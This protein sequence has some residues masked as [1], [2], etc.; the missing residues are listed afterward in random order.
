M[1][2][3]DADR[4]NFL[5]LPTDDDTLIRYWSLDEDDR[6]LL[7]TRRRNDTRLGLALQ[8]CALR[9]PGRLIQRGEVIPE[10]ALTFLAEQLGVDPD[11]IST[12][13]RR[14]PTR[15]EQLAILRQHYGFSELTHPLRADLL[16]FSCGVALAS[17]KDK[18]VVAALAD[19][20]RRRR[21]IIPGITV[22]ERL[23]GQACTE[24]EEALFADVARRLA[25]DLVVRMEA[26]LGMGP[27]A[28]QSGISWLREPPGKA[29]ASSMRGLID[30]LMAVRHVGISGHVLQAVPTHRVR[31]MAQEGRRLT[32]QNFEQ[33]RPGRRHATLAAFLL[34]TEIA[35]TDATIAMFET[36]IGKSF[37]QAE[38]LRDQKLLETATTA[39]S[40]L[41][42]FASFGDAI[43]ARRETGLSLDEAV[44][45]VTS[46][47]RLIEATASAKA[48]KRTR[49][50]DD[51]IAYLPA[52]YARIRRF[53]G[54]FLA[55]FTFEGNRQNAHF[56]DV[57]VQMAAGWKNGLRSIE[58]PW[59]R[60][61]LLLADRRWRKEIVAA[62][63]TIDRKMLELFLIVE[64]KNRIAANEIWIKGSHTYRAFDEHMIS[65]ETY[66]VIKAEARIPVAIP[67]DVEVYLAQKAEMLNQKLRE[68]DRRLETGR[69]DTRIGAKGLRVPTVRTVE[70]E[71]AIAF[72]K[73]IAAY[74]PPI[75][76]TDL[77]ADI[78]RITGFSSLF[79][80][81]QT[82][83]PPSDLRIFYAALIAE[84]TNLGF[85][86]MA[87]ACTGITRRQLQQMAIWH[88]RE[89]TFTLALARL[90]EAQHAA[91]FS[92]V[93]GSHAVS[94]SD[95]QHIHLG[96]GGGVSDLVFAFCHAL[97]FA[98]V[99]RI[100][101]LDGR[102]LYGFDP[103]KQYGILQN[104]MGDRIDADLIRAHWDDILRLMTSLRT[105]TV[106]A[107]LMLKRLSATTRQS[108]FAQALRQ[109]GRI[110]RTL[111]TLD[112]I[113][114]EQLRKTTTTELNKGESRNSLVRAV[115]LHRLGRFRDR[116]QENLSIRASALNLVVTAI[117]HWNTI[118]TGRVVDALREAGKAVP[119]HLLA[120]LS[121]LTWEHVNL[122]GDYLWEDKPAIDEN[123]FRAIPFIL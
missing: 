95:G 17:T 13:A 8:L 104:V 2:L 26:L 72:A 88:F 9:Y 53:S 119:Q 87:L 55:S 30:R 5:A 58:Q 122:T 68:A 75:R 73:R 3:T 31:R 7:E 49:A 34:E 62:D 100:P 79:E 45:A 35:L 21:I 12:F 103:A 63:G 71:A 57:V 36:L 10:G 106:S 85:S 67:V 110:E 90:V 84:A 80:H 111:F 19:E 18:Y 112:W 54:P 94:S 115:N 6:H 116:S 66:A 121:P 107:S 99:P 39:S 27:R 44:T 47:D 1:I 89:E 91:P 23:A 56:I 78:D 70:T 32:A 69:G 60:K 28:R 41:D 65:Q 105:R 120:S 11:A 93:F 25:P 76:L 50:D 92:A 109:M 123:G 4:Q 15:Y 16:A 51:L 113:N 74:M 64:L 24:A 61:A 81:L 29:G 22:L 37:R 46:W 42:F 97:G 82:G 86:K 14:A 117:I 38:S 98:F 48:A 83:R 40:A 101:D 102:C 108:G 96:D 33:M 59:V 118:Y 77:V 52:Q 20:M 114:D 43:T